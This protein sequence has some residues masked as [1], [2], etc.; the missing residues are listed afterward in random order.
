M[1]M[2]SGDNEELDRRRLLLQLARR[3]DIL[4]SKELDEEYHVRLYSPS[5]RS[6]Y[7]PKAPK[8]TIKQLPA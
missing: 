1:K 2:I 6:E 5:E 4:A 8:A 7:K 3:G